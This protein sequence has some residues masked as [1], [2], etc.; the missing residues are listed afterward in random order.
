MEGKL[1]QLIV[2][3]KD[4]DAALKFYTEKVGLEKRTEVSVPGSPRWLT[5]AL[6][7]QD[8]ELSL[9]QHGSI[10]PPDV[11]SAHLPLGNSAL[12]ITVPDC[13]K[14]FEELKSRGVHFRTTPS[15]QPWGTYAAFSDPDGNQ[16]TLLQPK[17]W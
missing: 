15:D 2:V 10:T 9:F 5:V 7:G 3:V 14:A 6:K 16:L 4:Q 8:V 12:T 1:T 13:R 17:K 11:P